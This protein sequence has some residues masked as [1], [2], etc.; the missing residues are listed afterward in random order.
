MALLLDTGIVYA[1]F[2]RKDSWH[3]PASRLLQRETDARLIPAPV[4]PEVDYLL[5][6]RLGVRA[7][8]T[9]CREL[10][11]G[12][13]VVVD[14][15]RESYSRILELTR[16]YAELRL[17]FVDAAVLALAEKLNLGRIATTDRKHFSVVKIGIPLELVPDP[18]S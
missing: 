2:D 17:G 8:E 15:P 4:I 6:D 3:E 12:S 14:L 13:L 7:Q 1:Y 9:F 10:A 11:E 16:Q 5:G 18:P